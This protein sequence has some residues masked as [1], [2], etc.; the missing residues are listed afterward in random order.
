MTDAV[1]WEEIE[2]ADIR[3]DDLIRL[4]REDGIRK[5]EYTSKAVVYEDDHKWWA[6][7]GA[8]YATGGEDDL[9]W[10]KTFYRKVKPFEVPQGLGAVVRAKNDIGEI[11]F[12]VTVDRDKDHWR[13]VNG[14]GYYS[15]LELLA[16]FTGHVTLSEGVIVF[17]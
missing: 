16:E 2:F 11:T 12:L 5:F 9:G 6:M 4:V 1:Q 10:T 15:D 14:N 13:E 3:A 8:W 17:A 7:D